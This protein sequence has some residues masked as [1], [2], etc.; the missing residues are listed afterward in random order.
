MVAAVAAPA[1]V[2]ENRDPEEASGAR[3][4]LIDLDLLAAP[5]HVAARVVVG[6]RDPRSTPK[7]GQ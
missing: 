3:E 4:P 2:V 6:D 1:K 7:T 5:G